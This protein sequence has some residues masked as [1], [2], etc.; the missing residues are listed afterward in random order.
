MGVGGKPTLLCNV[1]FIPI[2]E[3]YHAVLHCIYLPV[4]AT[5]VDVGLQ[6]FARASFPAAPLHRLQCSQSCRPLPPARAAGGAVRSSAG[7]GAPSPACLRPAAPQ[8]CWVA[9]A[10]EDTA[11]PVPAWVLGQKSCGFIYPEKVPYEDSHSAARSSPVWCCVPC[12][13]PPR[14]ALLGSL[15]REAPPGP[16]HPDAARALSEGSSNAEIH[17]GMGW[18]RCCSDTEV[19][20]QK[21]KV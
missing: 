13:P 7:A 15:P 19:T 16:Q 11:Q 18:Q 9:E 2:N 21:S 3:S 4:S 10:A 8:R 12:A 5:T 14:V 6:G 17:R 1:K 20:M